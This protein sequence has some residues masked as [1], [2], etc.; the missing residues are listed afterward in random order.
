ME[1]IQADAVVD[2]AKLE[3]HL[4]QVRCEQNLLMGAVGGVLAAILSAFTWA[5]VTVITDYQIGY[6]AAAVGYMVGVAIRIMGKG[7][8]S[9]FGYV[10]AILS[11]F[12]CL[13]GNF[14]SIVH[15]IAKASEATHMEVLVAMD[16]TIIPGIMLEEGSPIDLL[17]YGI[18][19][20]EGYKFSFRKISEEELTA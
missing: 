11:F 9:I 10:G 13:L 19:V 16:Y 20:Y 8:D 15:H 3:A 2:T 17:F 12:G 14:L 6:M 7:L 1:E 18:A 4:Q 5:L